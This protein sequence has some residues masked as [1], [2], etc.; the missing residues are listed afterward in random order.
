M[1]AAQTA[2]TA[3]RK[4]SGPG[5]ANGNIGVTLTFAAKPFPVVHSGQQLH[6][7][8]VFSGAGIVRR[9]VSIQFCIVGN[10]PLLLCGKR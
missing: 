7:F 4:P 1:L 8:T 3:V 2:A 10:A 9:P 6:I 5:L